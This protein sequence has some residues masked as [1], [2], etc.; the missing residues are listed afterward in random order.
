MLR[1]AGFEAVTGT[2]NFATLFGTLYLYQ[3]NKISI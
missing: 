3:G 2:P 1:L